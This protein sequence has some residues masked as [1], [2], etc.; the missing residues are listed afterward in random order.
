MA[1]QEFCT[2][3]YI[4]MVKCICLP[5]R[6]MKIRFALL[7]AF[8]IIGACGKK[9]ASREDQAR[10]MLTAFFT[11]I[12]DTSPSVTGIWLADQASVETMVEKRFLSG[13]VAKPDEMQ[14]TQLRER[15]RGLKVY[16]RIQGTEIQMLTTVADSFGLSKGTLIAKKGKSAKTQEFDAI[17]IGKGSQVR[18]R[19]RFH[20]EEKEPYL[21]YDESGVIISAHRE[22]RPVEELTA[23]YL[24]QLRTSTDLPQY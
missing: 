22:V 11:V 19:I 2:E 5:S 8:L 3:F 12:P 9:S 13:Y 17:L 20:K 23:M 15:L 18:A 1:W 16:Y 10:K 6:K 4:Y 14:I 24:E 21:E 7:G